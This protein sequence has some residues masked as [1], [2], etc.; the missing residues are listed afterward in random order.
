MT[1]KVYRLRSIRLLEFWIAPVL[2]TAL[3]AYVLYE[4]YRA[5]ATINTIKLGLLIG[6][7][8]IL[9][10]PFIWL[11]FDHLKKLGSA[12]LTFRETNMTYQNGR[13]TYAIDYDDIIGVV[14]YSLDRYGNSRLAW[15]GI[16][17]WKIKT[18]T[19][20]FFVSSLL[21]SKKD[22]KKLMKRDFQFEAT[23][24]PTL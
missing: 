16:I 1:E 5:D 3:M 7:F 6:V 21:I 19:N 14:E 8:L 18:A 4:D 20:E 2:I 15:S 17:K 22:L 9:I 13:D 12:Q 10:A 23:Y 24:F 11:F